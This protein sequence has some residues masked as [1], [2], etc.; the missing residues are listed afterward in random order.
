MKYRFRLLVSC[1]FLVTTF[2]L[3]F[4]YAMFQGGFVSWFL[5]FS[6]LPILIYEVA[7]LI[8]PIRKWKVGRHLSHYISNASGAITVKLEVKRRFPFPLYYCILEDIMPESLKTIDNQV[9][10]FQYMNQPERL[11]V[12]R[13]MKKML[14][15]GFK[16]TFSFTYRLEQIPR[17]EHQFQT[18]RIRTGDFFGLVKKEHYFAVSDLLVTYPNARPWLLEGQ[19]TNRQEGNLLTASLRFTNANVATGIREYMPGDRFSW[20]DWKQ[21]ARKNTVMTKEFEQEKGTNMLLVLDACNSLNPIIFEGMVEVTY[22]LLTYLRKQ[23]IETGLLTIGKSGS[24]YPSTYGVWEF[25]RMKE[26]LTQLQPNKNGVFSLAIQSYWNKLVNG[27]VLLFV[28]GNV[29]KPF[30]EMIKKLHQRTE[31]IHVLLVQPEEQQKKSASL[32]RQLSAFGVDI[33]EMTE[34][35]LMKTPLE[36]KRI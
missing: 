19:I 24:F 7:V 2:L 16:R 28:V 22:S 13:Q 11:V 14:L 32:V 6:F 25:D 8:Y 35:E 9:G 5:F 34:H 20:I 3:L 26:H 10:K 17:G 18:V 23:S 12:K 36:V 30:V 15:P 33:Y 4:S 1:L 27:G 31:H 29:D 21:T